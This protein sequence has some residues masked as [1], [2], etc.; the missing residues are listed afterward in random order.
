MW[1]GIESNIVSV[2]FTITSANNCEKLSDPDVLGLKESHYK[3]D[4]SAQKMK[5]FIKD[6][7]SKCD[8]IRSFLRRLV[9]NRVSLGR[10]NKPLG[11]DQNGSLGRLKSLVKNL[12]QNLEIDI[13]SDIGIQ[14]QVQ[15]KN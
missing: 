5:F 11:N 3:H 12:K 6:F 14:E 4:Y 2:L 1:P 9:W 10:R 8:Q 13:A 7:F 15:N